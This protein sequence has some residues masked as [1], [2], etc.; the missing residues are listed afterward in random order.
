[1]AGKLWRIEL[2]GGLRVSGEDRVITRFR[3]QKTGTL[4]GV[5]AL[6]LGRAITRARLLELLW[7]DSDEAAARNSLSV[8]L[9]SL[10]GQLEPPG[11]P[12]DSVLVADRLTVLLRAETVCCDLVE[13][14]RL[15]TEAQAAERPGQCIELLS[16]AADLALGELLDGYVE[17]WLLPEQLRIA[18]RRSWALSELVDRLMAIGDTARALP[19]AQRLV[20]DEPSAEASHTRLMALYLAAGEVSA[21]TRQFEQLERELAA[22][23]EVPSAAARALLA[24]VEVQA[25][26]ALT[27]STSETPP[28]LPLAGALAGTLAMLR[29]EPA[30]DWPGTIERVL[31]HGGHLTR[32]G[33]AV[34]GRTTD[35]LDCALALVRSGGEPLGI[36]LHTGEVGEEQDQGPLARVAEHLLLAGHPGQILCS[37]PAAALLRRDLQPGVWLVDL[38]LYRLA[39]GARPMRVSQVDATDLPEHSFP[40]LRAEAGQ[41]GNL[42]HQITRFFGRAAE[43]DR[44]E[45]LLLDDRARLVTLTGPGGTGKTRLALETGHRL[46]DPFGGSVWFVPLADVWDPELVH[47][48][49]L[50]SLGVARP[51]EREPL[52][53]L[54][55][56]LAGHQSLL[57]LDNYEQLVETG[58][59]A[60]HALL[61]R[62]PTVSCLVSSRQRL[63]VAG[64][65]EFA[66]PPLPTPHGTTEP[67]LLS[68]CESVQLFVDRAQAV[69]PDFALTATNAPAVAELC[70][71][72]EGIPLA[73]ELAAS[74]AQVLTPQQM[75]ERLGKP[76]DLLVSRRRDTAERHRT[77]RAAVE[78][79][80][81]LLDP[82]L[83]A[84]YAR[85]SVFAGGCSLEAVEAVCDNPLALDDLALLRESSLLVAEQV[86]EAVRYRCLETLRAYAA[87][88]LAAHGDE[89]VWQARHAAFFVDLAESMQTHLEAGEDPAVL[90]RLEAERENFRR[91]LDWCAEHDPCQG[92]RLAGALWRFWMVRG[93]W[94]EGR[95]A[96]TAAL[97]RAEDAPADLRA[98]VL[99]RAGHLA[100]RGGDYDGARAHLDACLA[101]SRELDD[102]AGAG[103][104]L[105]ELGKVAWGQGDYAAAREFYTESLAARRATGNRWGEAATLGNL[106]SVASA[107]CD[108]AAAGAWLRASLDLRTELGDRRGM[109]G[110][111]ANLGVVAFNTGRLDEAREHF[112]A[113]LALRRETGDTGGVASSLSDLGAL[114]LATGDLVAAR[115]RYAEALATQRELGDQRGI[116]LTLNNLGIIAFEQGEWETARRL[117]RE[118]YEAQTAIGNRRGE[119][120]ALLNLGD[121]AAAMGEVELAQTRYAEA[122]ERFDELGDTRA[123]LV[124]RLNLAD[125][126][127]ATGH[128]DRAEVAFRSLLAAARERGDEQL[129]TAARKGL[130]EALL[131]LGRAEEA[132]PELVD[133]LH[134]FTRYDDRRG[135]LACLDDLARAAAVEGQPDRAARYITASDQQRSHQGVPRRPCDER[136]VEPL[137]TAELRPIPP[138]SIDAVLADCELVA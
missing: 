106:G 16:Q 79:S 53:A 61:E 111:L 126:A 89:P 107:Q 103:N 99:A 68:R 98:R 45:G 136:W 27:S 36:A 57:I 4:L 1:M 60:V 101:L 58:A 38:G 92:L 8:A 88:R 124:A 65:H 100:Y 18:G 93:Y 131:A 20:V 54:S 14:E 22:V 110:S 133:A 138:E 32:P 49:I 73:I 7:P 121:I 30:N 35:A 28:P 94:T 115:A 120:M 74:R 26:P 123:V 62:I 39:P 17:D 15:L 52:E 119:A 21:A 72:L 37:E 23:D 134:W 125:L 40:P 102:L 127:I 25:A 135:V 137:R 66:V 34:F 43:L 104:A 105:N 129:E 118:G 11:T 80:Y 109:A 13:F 67:E 5:L 71:R 41:S 55:Q 3:T 75:L 29:F 90:A 2:L 113:S 64:E 81:Q 44:V 117:Y 122:L 83:Q 6:N 9:S 86:G 10:R 84:F 12:K 132:R 116:A 56:A 69:R 24:G 47:D 19:Y 46:L 82:E 33:A 77:L 59:L 42:P 128:A 78:W 51:P 112:E 114:L 50:A 70:A 130:G 87:E 76:L 95:A 63:T 97:A 48:T 96:M 108:F 85:V 31:S 91:A